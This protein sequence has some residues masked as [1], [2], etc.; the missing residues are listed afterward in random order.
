MYVFPPRA[1]AAAV[2][3]S[4]VSLEDRHYPLAHAAPL[5]HTSENLDRVGAVYDAHRARVLT[6]RFCVACFF[7]FWKMANIYVSV[8]SGSITGALQ[9]VVNDWRS[10]RFPCE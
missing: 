9:S 2:R 1:L 5:L 8:T 4:S 3:A 10:V 7:V 6:L